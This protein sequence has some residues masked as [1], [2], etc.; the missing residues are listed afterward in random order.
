MRLECWA[1]LNHTGVRF[2]ANTSIH[3]LPALNQSQ[4]VI[5]T[6]KTDWERE[7]TEASGSLAYHLSQT[8]TSSRRGVSQSDTERQLPDGVFFTSSKGRT[9]ILNGSHHSLSHSGIGIQKETVL[10]FPDYR[11]ISSVPRSVDGAKTL[12]EKVA[13]IETGQPSATTKEDMNTY[14]LPYACVILLCAFLCD[15]LLPDNAQ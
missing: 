9:S 6:G 8:E 4:F 10:L 5:S 1:P 14:V 12:W 3:L 11:I 2:V 13:E 15:L 7:V